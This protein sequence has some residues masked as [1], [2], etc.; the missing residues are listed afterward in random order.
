VTQ[1]I[2]EKLATALMASL[3]IVLGSSSLSAGAESSPVESI[4]QPQGLN[5]S[6]I[7]ALR[8]I[9]PTLTGAS[10]KFAVVC[11]SYT[12]IG[13]AP[14]NDYQPDVSHDCFNAD[15]FT[16]HDDSA[17]PAGVSPHSTAVCSILVGEDPNAFHPEIGAFYY[18]GAAPQAQA[19]IY[20]FLYFLTNNVGHHK[21][22]DA[23]IITA[24]W[25]SQFEDWWTRGI[26]SLA[27]HY[28][29]IVVASIGNGA[30][31]HDPVFYPGAAANAIGVGVVDSVNTSDL[32]TR[33]AHFALAYPDHSSSGPT[34]DG[35]CKP[36][37]VAPGN[38]LAADVG[39]PN[40]YEP[41]GNGSSFSTPVVAGTIGLLVQKAK[42]DP[43][44]SP[45]VS[46]NGG[47]CVMKAI[48]LN[49][50]T[51]LP[52]WHKGRLGTDD[53]HTVPLD[54]IQGAGMVNAVGAY[55]TLVAGPDKPGDVPA[56]GWDVNIVDKDQAA[57]N[58][59]RISIPDPAGKIITVTACWNKHYTYTSPFD[60]IPGKNSNLRLELWAVDP[61][62]EQNDYLL[63]YSDSPVDNVEHVYVAADAAF[64][65]YRVVLTFSDMANQQESPSQRY[66]LA[67]SVSGKQQT[68][69]I[70]WYD[71][72]ADGIVNEADFVILLNNAANSTK[73]P[74]SY[75]LGDVKAD[76]LIDSGDL[77]LFLEHNNLQADWLAKTPVRSK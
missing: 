76:G 56:T 59:Y 70:L 18:Q 71:L 24:S 64:T 50:A 35:R 40:G 37:I 38:C 49:S 63:D 66:G 27:E 74:E 16:F 14:Q 65:D 42:Q 58:S 4:L 23:D 9:D 6:G 32:A 20:E 22:P 31:S 52:Y 61:A 47:N 1:T 5:D 3:V 30:D 41:V 75:W 44:L 68:D 77:E 48:L 15:H 46:P 11:R 13:E 60:A 73:S 29:L 26:E 17:L 55:K 54:Y 36:D 2:G 57:E 53:D 39:D 72:N 25:G 28:G 51:K 21:P 8:E 10:V 67:W 34:A 19:D 45:A 62:D 12:Y 69:N 43:R 33:L 7:Y